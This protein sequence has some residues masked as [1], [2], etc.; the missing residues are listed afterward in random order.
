MSAVDAVRQFNRMYTRRLG[1]LERGL[2]DS[3]LS[4]TEV[5]VLYELAHGH[6]RCARDL[7]ERL[8]ID[9][10]YASRILAGF[11]R[12]DRPKQ[13]PTDAVSSS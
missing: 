4:L 5:R 1:L 13:R 7:C 10:G 6:A 3:E 8:G 12:K 11:A 9:P 2:L